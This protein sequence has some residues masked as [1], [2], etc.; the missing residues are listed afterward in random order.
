LIKTDTQAL[1]HLNLL[2]IDIER[3]TFTRRR[4]PPYILHNTDY[5]INACKRGTF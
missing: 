3:T 1:R 5:T 4:I 2:E